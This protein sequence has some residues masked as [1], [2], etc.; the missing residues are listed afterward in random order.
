MPEYI[1]IKSKEK[2]I[3]DYWKELEDVEFSIYIAKQ[4][5]NEDELPKLERKRKILENKIAEM[6]K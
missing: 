2:T 5:D 4:S 6:E 3:E 1:P